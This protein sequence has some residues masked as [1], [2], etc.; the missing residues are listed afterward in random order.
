[1]NQIDSALLLYR[2]DYTKSYLY[3]WVKSL[4]LFR[5]GEY[6]QAQEAFAN[7]ESETS[8]YWLFLQVLNGQ[9]SKSRVEL[10]R[11]LNHCLLWMGMDTV[12][13]LTY[14]ALGEYDRADSVASLIDSR[15]LGPLS[16]CYNLLQ[17]GEYFHFT[18]NAKLC[19][20][21]S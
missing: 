6:S 5:K 19:R 11:H 8:G 9:Y 13:I 3:A 14:N 15:V 1:M 20:Q 18:G 17:L 4:L 10:D 2:N 21:T 12:S 16:L 7:F